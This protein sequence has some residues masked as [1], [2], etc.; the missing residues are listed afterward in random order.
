MIDDLQNRSPGPRSSVPAELT[1]KMSWV[2][3]HN[4]T[5][6]VRN[7]VLTTILDATLR[8]NKYKAKVTM[9]YE[10]Y[11]GKIVER[12]G[13]ALQGWPCGEIRNPSK[14]GSH[15]EV[16]KLLEALK[17]GECRWVTLSDEEIAQRK[18]TNKAHQAR[19]ETVYKSRKEGPR[20]RKSGKKSAKSAAI[21][22]SDLDDEEEH[23]P[24]ED[25]D[26]D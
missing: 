14:V 10:N 18:A 15:Q 16:T 23:E 3:T 13:V 6:T 22:E 4:V 5:L 21:V 7:K 19:G 20:K 9:N 11:E 2:S 24:P 26:D 8:E 12:Y 25:S 1:F 17:S